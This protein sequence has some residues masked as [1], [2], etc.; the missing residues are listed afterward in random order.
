MSGAKLFNFVRQNSTGNFQEVIPEATDENI[1]TISNL[2]FRQGSFVFRRDGKCS[3]QP[4]KAS[5]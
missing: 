5:C 2:L 3:R 1:A 4:Q